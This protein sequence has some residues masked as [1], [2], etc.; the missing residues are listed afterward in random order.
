VQ[1]V[2]R[3]LKQEEDRGNLR[4]PLD[5]HDLAYLIIRIAESFIYNDIITGEE[6]DA[7]KAE[8][9]VAALLGADLS[10][11]ALRAQPAVSSG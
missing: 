2:E 11:R 4:H 5:N 10:A 3:L 6:P 7:A 1:A 8:V 9:A